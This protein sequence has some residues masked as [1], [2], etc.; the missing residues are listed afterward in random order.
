MQGERE[1]A[2]LGGTKPHPFLPRAT[3]PTPAKEA[4]CYLCCPFGILGFILLGL[5]PLSSC[6]Q[7]F[8]LRL[9]PK[10]DR[11]AWRC[12]T[13]AF[14][15]TRTHLTIRHRKLDLD[16]LVLELIDCGCPAVAGLAHRADRLLS[17]PINPEITGRKALTVLCL[18]VVVTT[19]R[20]NQLDAI[21]G[22]TTYKQR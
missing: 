9:W 11:P 8:V 1:C 16:H 14:L 10:C 19:C 20:S 17:F 13:R 18:P 12:R 4:V 6:Q 3:R 5:F 7:C 21:A 15:A 22:L 2:T